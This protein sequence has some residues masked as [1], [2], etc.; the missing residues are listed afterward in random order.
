MS[1]GVLAWLSVW[2]EVQTFICSSW[3]HCHSLS[4][5]SVKSR[6]VLPFWY[7][8]TWVVL[9][10]GPLNGRVCVC[11]CVCVCVASSVCGSRASCVSFVPSKVIGLEERLWNDPFCVKWDVISELS[12][13]RLCKFTFFCTKTSWVCRH[14]W[15]AGRWSVKVTLLLLLQ[16]GWCWRPA[17]GASQ[18]DSLLRERDVDYVPCRLK[19]VWSSSCRVR[20]RG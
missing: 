13:S 19:R 9:E 6:L 20:Q 3:C 15:S 1:G 12:Q 14:R 10:K 17:V 5:A 11:V 8:L 2:S 4:L 7:R 16:D 18:V